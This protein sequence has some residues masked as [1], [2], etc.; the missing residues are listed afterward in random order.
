MKVWVRI[1]YKVLSRNRAP[2]QGTKSFFRDITPSMR[3]GRESPKILVIS[4][5]HASA[6]TS[7]AFS[8]TLVNRTATIS[9]PLPARNPASSF[10]T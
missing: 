10:L 4:S 8:M 9:A 7:L 2:S 3:S 5:G 1:D 6:Y